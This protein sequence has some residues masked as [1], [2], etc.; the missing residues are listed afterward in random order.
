M[1][2][3]TF[4]A[5]PELFI[6]NNKTKKVVSAIDKIPGTKT[7][8]FTEGLPK[9]FGLQTDNILAEFNIPAAKNEQEF[10]ESIEFM[11]DKIRNIVQEI[12]SNLDILC[13]A[14]SKVPAKELKHPQAKL[15][16]CDPDYCIYT[17]TRNEPGKL[18]RTTTRSAG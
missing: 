9:G 12:D 2:K 6:F 3:Y 5:D 14:S 16:G 1:L 7:N 4:G 10:V 8:P 11:K 13:Q 18:G 15:A 17:N